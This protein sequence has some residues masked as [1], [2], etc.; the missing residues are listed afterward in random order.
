MKGT[1]SASRPRPRPRRGGVLE[2]YWT[3]E[4]N[5]TVTWLPKVS[6]P[7]FCS[8]A[9]ALYA[10]DVLLSMHHLGY[11]GISIMSGRARKPSLVEESL[12][13]CQVDAC[14]TATQD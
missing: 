10:N 3:L 11:K 7:T 9:S 12:S 6:A 13:L 1:H 14:F 2:P 8:M 5:V 4:L